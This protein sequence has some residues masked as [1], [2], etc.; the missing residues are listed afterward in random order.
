MHAPCANCG[1][2]SAF[3]TF[4][5]DRIKEAFSICILCLKTA[6]VSNNRPSLSN[7]LQMDN[8]CAEIPASSSCECGSE[9]ARLPTHS[10]WCPKH[11]RNEQ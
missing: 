5:D 11:A 9:T 2:P 4:S 3:I 8:P 10:T 1:D 6:L 7:N